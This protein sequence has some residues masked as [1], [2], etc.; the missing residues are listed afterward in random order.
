MEV[1]HQYNFVLKVRKVLKV[2]LVCKP[3]ESPNPSVGRSLLIGADFFK[4][5]ASGSFAFVV[6][7]W[8]FYEFSNIF[9]INF[10]HVLSPSNKHVSITI[11]PSII[12]FNWYPPPHYAV[13]YFLDCFHKPFNMQNDFWTLLTSY[14][15]NYLLS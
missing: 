13:V 10:R 3:R 7:F 1:H 12:E 2:R 5:V 11:L 4:L 14:L 6:L 15:F 9:S 8:I